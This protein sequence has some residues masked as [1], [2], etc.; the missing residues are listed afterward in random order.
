MSTKKSIIKPD[1]ENP[2]TATALPS[3]VLLVFPEAIP[4]ATHLALTF[5]GGFVGTTAMVYCATKP[6]DIENDVDLGL[7][8]GGYIYPE[9]KNKR[10]VFE[11]VTR[12]SLSKLQ[13]CMADIQNTVSPGHSRPI[14]SYPEVH[15]RAARTHYLT[16]PDRIPRKHRHR[17]AR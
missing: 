10:Q 13:G 7:T 4:N 12:P 2:W 6:H 3:S 8:M 9:D 15:R 1:N 14:R 5:Q 17:E 11:Y 16:H